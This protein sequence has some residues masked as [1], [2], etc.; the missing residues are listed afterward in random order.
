MYI[1]TL[2][3]KPFILI[4]VVC[5]ERD[6]LMLINLHT[7]GSTEDFFLS[8]EWRLNTPRDDKQIRRRARFISSMYFFFLLDWFCA[9]NIRSCWKIKHFSRYIFKFKHI[10]N[11]LNIMDKL[12]IFKTLN[13]P[14]RQQSQYFPQNYLT[15]SFWHL[16]CSPMWFHLRDDSPQHIVQ[17]L[18]SAEIESCLK[19]W[20]VT[21]PCCYM[22][23]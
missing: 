3:Y 23:V 2:F 22:H 20:N 13:E 1:V 7:Q 14:N 6:Y 18:V 10:T 8:Y 21:E 12:G 17:I 4:L 11:L 5:F 9:W 19:S 15:V 16:L